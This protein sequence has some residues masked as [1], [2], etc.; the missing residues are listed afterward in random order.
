MEVDCTWGP[1]LP[2]ATVA[3]GSN[4]VPN[5]LGPTG[6]PTAQLLFV[7][8][9]CACAPKK[10]STFVATGHGPLALLST[11]KILQCWRTSIRLW[12]S[13]LGSLLML[14]NGGHHRSSYMIISNMLE[15][16]QTSKYG[17]WLIQVDLYRL[18]HLASATIN[19]YFR[20][21]SPILGSVWGFCGIPI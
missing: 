3:T 12:I 13:L 16:V 17:S 14:A 1:F 21:N 2:H 18:L 11:C 4:R 5:N 9:K 15:H 19:A 6:M 7:V 8:R 10:K 20:T